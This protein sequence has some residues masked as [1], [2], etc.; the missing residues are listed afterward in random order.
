MLLVP[1]KG[2]NNN[3]LTTVILQHFSEVLHFPIQRMRLEKGF[4]VLLGTLKT[5]AY[6]LKSLKDVID[7]PLGRI[8]GCRFSLI[9]SFIEFLRAIGPVSSLGLRG[10]F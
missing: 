5:T 7:G 3:F 8:F 1:E 4:L 9:L 2:H 10:G 6:S